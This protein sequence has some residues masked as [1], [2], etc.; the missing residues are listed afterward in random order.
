MTIEYLP[1]GIACNISCGYCYQDPM[2]Q[3]GNINVPRDWAKVK[4]QIDRLG[5]DFSVFGG[6]PLLTPLAHLEE[7]FAYGFE[8]FGKNGIQTNGSLI[9]EAHLRL[10]ERYRVQVG[11]SIDGPEELNQVRCAP[12]LTRRTL[13][14]IDALCARGMPPSIIT[15]IHQGN[16]D[17]SRLL[18]WF[19]SL[20]A[21][22]V[23]YLNLHELEVDCG[24]DSTA[25]SEEENIRVYLALYEWAQASPLTVMPFSDIRA[26]LTEEFPRVACT[27]NHC[28]PMT[29]AAVQ[30]INPRGEMSNCGRTNKDGVNWLKGTPGFERY[31]ALHYTP[32][33]CG[34]C[35]GCTYFVFCKGHCPGTAIDGDWRN[36]T[37]HCRFWYA[38]FERIERD[39]TPLTAE[40][41]DRML[42]RLL[43]TWVGHGDTHGDGHGDSP[44]GDEHGDH[45]DHGRIPATILERRPDDHDDP[46]AT[47]GGA[48]RA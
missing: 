40:V 13:A 25:L 17:L 4:D 1:V 33:E 41:K 20:A 14:A 7:V 26:L 30:G 3:A 38:L 18:P 16:A 8:K 42:A 28:D 31:L 19:D 15:T 24:R 36:R 35:A 32:Q 46:G 43:A 34:G 10:F 39:C 22:G 2:R 47:D 6:E 27:W 11:I 37:V 5:S 44:H 29:T 48:A 21:K 45:T 12:E 23:R 9:T